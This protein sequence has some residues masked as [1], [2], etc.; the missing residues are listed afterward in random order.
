MEAPRNNSLFAR[1]PEQHRQ[2]LVSILKDSN[3]HLRGICRFQLFWGVHAVTQLLQQW[4]QT[5]LH[6]INSSY[7]PLSFQKQKDT[8]MMVVGGEASGKS[9]SHEAG[10]S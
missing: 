5:K 8:A 3:L 9:L 1:V 4:E 7:A 2:L 6:L 10:A